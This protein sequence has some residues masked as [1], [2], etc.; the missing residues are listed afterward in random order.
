MVTSNIRGGPYYTLHVDHEELAHGRVV[1]DPC[2]TEVVSSGGLLFDDQVRLMDPHT[3]QPVAQDTVGEIW[4]RGPSVARGYWR[5][6]EATAK[7]FLDLPDGRWL[8]SG[9]LAFL[10]NGGL[11]ITSRAKDVIIIRG[12]N[13]Y[14]QDIEKAVEQGVEAVRKGRVAAFPVQ[15]D[16]R[17]CIGIAAEIGRSVQKKFDPQTLIDAID[18]VVSETQQEPASV[19]ALLEP[20]AL[21]KTT[22]GKLQRSA[23]RQRLETGELGAYYVYRRPVA[24]LVT[25]GQGDA[26]QGDTEQRLATIWSDVLEGVEVSRDDVFLAKG[27]HSLAAVQVVA[28]VRAEFNVELPLSALF[29]AKPLARLAAMVDAAPRLADGVPLRREQASGPQAMSPV[30]RS[31][32]LAQ[33]LGGEQGR[34]A[35][36]MVARLLLRGDL[37]VDALQAALGALVQRQASLRSAFVPGPDGVA[38]VHCASQVELALPLLDLSGLHGAEQA[39]ALAVAEAEA[40]GSRSICNGRRCCALRCCD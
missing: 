13:R 33:Q 23:C 34:A 6:P 5:N 39:T 40:A 2:G 3:L 7:T 17:E 22:S 16:G 37:R 29:A 15:V 28:R 24:G 38:L 14:P 9:D 20:A 21:P 30:Q 31:L 27:G 10:H 32:W 35:Y 26:P 4:V 12:Q 36:N 18:R 11:F 1:P 19:I 8:R 25:A